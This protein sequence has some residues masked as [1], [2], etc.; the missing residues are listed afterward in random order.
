[1]G[2]GGWKYACVESY[3]TKCHKDNRSNN[4]DFMVEE[5]HDVF[6]RGWRIHIAKNVYFYTDLDKSYTTKLFIAVRHFSHSLSHE[7]LNRC[8]VYRCFIGA[9]HWVWLYRKKSRVWYPCLSESVFHFPTFQ[10]H[11]GLRPKVIYLTNK[12]NDLSHRYLGDSL[13][14]T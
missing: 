13:K 3:N 14:P 9:L 12:N 1:M 7:T 8:P 10:G 2:G 4:M 5:L 11:L 6:R